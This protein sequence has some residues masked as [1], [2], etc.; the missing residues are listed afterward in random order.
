MFNDKRRGD[1]YWMT[2]TPLRE[3]DTHILRGDRPAVIVSS[4]E[5]NQTSPTV[6]VIP[7]TTSAAKLER[8]DGYCNNVLLMSLNL[9]SVAVTRQ[10]RT[11]D[12]DDLQRYLGHLPDREMTRLDAVLHRVL[13]L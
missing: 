9:P 4:D 1:V 3:G 10:V 5:V 7:L 12:A 13:G 8:G 11:I 2:D 6:T